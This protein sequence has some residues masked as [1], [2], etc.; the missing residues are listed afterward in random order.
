VGKGKQRAAR[1]AR[2]RK[3]GKRIT[4]S[5][6]VTVFKPQEVRELTEYL[7]LLAWP[8]PWYAKQLPRP[9]LS[10]L[11]ILLY[12]ARHGLQGKIK[13]KEPQNGTD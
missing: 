9:R 10:L 5:N 4:K 2:I 13:Y 6:S 11:N 8:S 7:D 3:G 12:A 1:R